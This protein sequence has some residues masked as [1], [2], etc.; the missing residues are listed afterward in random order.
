MRLRVQDGAIIKTDFGNAT[1]YN[2]NDEYYVR[3]FNPEVG[4][5]VGVGPFLAQLSE[6]NEKTF[7]L[8]YRHPF[9]G[10]ELVCDICIKSIKKSYASKNRIEKARYRHVARRKQKGCP[11]I[12]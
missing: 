11:A 3:H 10:R 4:H 6:V 5:L 8:D 9:G 12:R 2:K 1:L 7:V